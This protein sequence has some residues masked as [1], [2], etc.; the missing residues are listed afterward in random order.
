M[1]KDDHEFP[2]R[3][4]SHK[5]DHLTKLS[6]KTRHIQ[7]IWT[8]FLTIVSFLTNWILIYLRLLYGECIQIVTVRQA[9]FLLSYRHSSSC[10]PS[11][12]LSEAT[13]CRNGGPGAIC[14]EMKYSVV[15]DL[16]L[17]QAPLFSVVSDSHVRIW[18]EPQKGEKCD[19]YLSNSTCLFYFCHH[20]FVFFCSK[21]FL[22]F[23]SSLPSIFNIIYI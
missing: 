20:C 22:S 18:Y 21:S 11:K 19:S 17:R 2:T 4:T 16:A 6:V 7:L 12:V 14:C 1:W 5:T 3:T 15:L 23:I 9:V 13:V 10:P 8:G